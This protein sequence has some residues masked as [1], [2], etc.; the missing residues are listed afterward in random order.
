MAARGRSVNPLRRPEAPGPVTASPPRA[1]LP[2]DRK[3]AFMEM[4]ITF[5][6]GDRVD[7][8]FDGIR[9]TTHQDGS[10]P[11]P[12]ALFLASIG[13]CAGIYVSRFCRQRGIPTEGVRIRQVAHWDAATRLVARIDLEIELPADFPDPYRE[14]VVRAANLCA[15]KKHLDAP[16]EIVVRAG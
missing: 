3:E 11:S 14:A 8:E 6:E 10:A 15:V 13:T 2:P 12:F 4:R 1:S 16:P 9:V 7:A 5:P